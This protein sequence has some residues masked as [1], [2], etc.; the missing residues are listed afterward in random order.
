[1]VLQAYDFLELYRRHYAILQ[2]GGSDQWD[3]MA[4]GTELERHIEGAKLFSL[5]APLITTSEG[6]PMGLQYVGKE[7]KRAS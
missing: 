7:T 3:N 1:M 4:S 2:I 5:T 6:K